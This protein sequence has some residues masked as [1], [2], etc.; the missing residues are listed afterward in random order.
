M[1]N[2][3]AIVIGTGQSGP[4]LARRLGVM[5]WINAA[6]MR[7]RIAVAFSRDVNRGVQ[8]L[9]LP[10]LWN[11][12]RTVQRKLF[13]VSWHSLIATVRDP[14]T[15]HLKHDDPTVPVGNSRSAC[16]PYGGSKI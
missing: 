1:P 12:H 7:A 11:R 2:H 16:A 9:G 8:W 3:D 4:A 6:I 15:L 13:P 5:Q 14:M 10:D